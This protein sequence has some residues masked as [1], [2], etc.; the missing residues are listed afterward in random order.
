M[1]RKPR[2][3]PVNQPSHIYQRGNNRGAMFAEVEDY[4]LF[5]SY[6]AQSAQRHEVDIHAWVF[7]TNHFHLLATPKADEAV[8]RMMQSLGRNYVK[9]FNWK[10]QRTGTLFEGRFKNH[11]IESERYFLN[12]QL[13]IEL[14][15]VRAGMVAKATDFKWSS[16]RA[17]ARGIAADMWT[18]HPIYL[19]MATSAGARRK[20]YQKL[21]NVGQPEFV[22]D[23]IRTCTLKGVPL[24]EVRE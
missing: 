17:H 16:V 14:N 23:Q 2:Y 19:Q 13:Y 22:V 9:Y 5:A 4:Q 12:C 1:P 8:S 18:P 24:G 20:A 15:P 21:L 3:C 6:L 7:M 11:I 10:Y